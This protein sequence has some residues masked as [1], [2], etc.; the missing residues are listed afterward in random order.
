MQIENESGAFQGK[1]VDWPGGPGIFESTSVA[2]DQV[3][4]LERLGGNGLTWVPVGDNGI[5]TG[6]SVVAFTL[7]KSIVRLD[8]ASGTSV[9]ADIKT[10]RFSP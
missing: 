5:A 3:V 8:M 1:P 4:A 6:N 10:R 9:Y 7:D 2:N